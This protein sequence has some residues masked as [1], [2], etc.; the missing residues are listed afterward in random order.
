MSE[1]VYKCTITNGGGTEQD[2]GDFIIQ[3]TEKTLIFECV[4]YPFFSAYNGMIDRKKI[5]EGI[6]KA[7][8][9]KISKQYSKKRV[10]EDGNYNAW[11]I[12]NEPLEHIGYFNNGHVARAWE[13]GT[14]TVYPNQSGIP[15]YLE[16]IET[17]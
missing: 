5:A 15:H 8:P 3:E 12:V 6:Y 4:R 11:R 1:K 14:W 2:G 7:K 16:E 17:L 13:D 10:R 9:V